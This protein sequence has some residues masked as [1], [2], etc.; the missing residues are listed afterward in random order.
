VLW[1]CFASYPQELTSTIRDVRRE[2]ALLVLML[3]LLSGCK[4]KTKAVIVL[5]DQWAVKQAEADCRSRQQEGVPLCASDPTVMIRDFEAQTA[6]AFQANP[7][8][9]GITLVTLNSS[10]DPLQLNSKW[11]FIEL[12]RSNVAGELRYTVARTHDPHSHGSE[13]GQGVPD[14]IV[15]GICSFV[16]QG[17]TVE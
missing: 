13:T 1:R 8:C 9:R 5:D 7:E 14:S 16:L 15:G 11:L 17:G 4:Q 12:M 3:C 2:S 10:E 6:R